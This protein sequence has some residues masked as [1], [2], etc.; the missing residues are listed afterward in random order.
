M[1]DDAL[2]L[3]KRLLS[4]F[5]KYIVSLLINPLPSLHAAE[6]ERFITA[7]IWCSI[8]REAFQFFR[9]APTSQTC[10]TLSFLPGADRCCI[11]YTFKL[12]APVD[13]LNAEIDAILSHFKE[14][15]R[16]EISRFAEEKEF[17]VVVLAIYFPRLLSPPTFKGS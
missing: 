5:V 8:R 9:T 12:W 2:K 17:A 16:L 10:R 6:C 1:S 14:A 4:F 7:D 13:H 3:F 15:R 11:Y